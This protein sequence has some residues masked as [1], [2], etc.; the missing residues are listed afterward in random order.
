MKT[1]DDDTPPP[2]DRPILRQGI[3]GGGA[4][5]AF[6]GGMGGFGGG[7]PAAPADTRP[8]EERF[9]V[10]LQVRLLSHLF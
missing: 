7:A 1:V 2:P 10:Q 4:F 8:P 5:G 3:F 9:Q 6:G